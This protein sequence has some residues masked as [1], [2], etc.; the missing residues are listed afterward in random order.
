MNFWK[1]KKENDVNTPVVNP[2]L[3]KAFKNFNLNRTEATLKALSDQ[4]KAATYLVLVNTEELNYTETNESGKKALE[5]GSKINFL[6]TFDEQG[7]SFLPVFTDWAEIDLWLTNKENI[8]GWMMSA[9][10]V[11]TLALKGNY[12][13]L[14]INLCT[15]KWQMTKDQINLFIKET[16]N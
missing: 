7:N 11:F 4:I 2:G 15:D 9:E 14:V 13:G 10:D 16:Q 5:V 12:K 6:K 8:A 3:K 1:K